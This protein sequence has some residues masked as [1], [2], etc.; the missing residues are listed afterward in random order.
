MV[1]LQQSGIFERPC[2]L[3]ISLWIFDTS[4]LDVFLFFGRDVSHNGKGLS[5]KLILLFLS[6]S[7]LLFF[8]FI[9]SLYFYGGFFIGNFYSKERRAHTEFLFFPFSSRYFSFT[10]FLGKAWN[11][12]SIVIIIILFFHFVRLNRTLSPRDTHTYERIF[13]DFS[14]PKFFLFLNRVFLF[15]LSSWQMYLVNFPASRLPRVSPSSGSV[16]RRAIH[17]ITLPLSFSRALILF[18]SISARTE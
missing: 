18:L 3:H 15:S 13:H 4:F 17:H 2:N 16:S 6:F 10:S 11:F 5:R 1:D 8:F 9:I 12:V 7:S 14:W